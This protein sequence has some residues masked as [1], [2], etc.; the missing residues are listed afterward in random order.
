MDLNV[1]KRLAEKRV[2]GL[3]KLAADIGMSE[4]N[5]HRCINNNKMQGGDLEQIANI[6]GVSVDIFFDET[7]E[8]Y[9]D[10]VMNLK[11][12]K[13]YIEQQGLSLVSLATKINISRIALD[14]IL[15]GS[16]VK[17]STVDALA[18]ALNVNV[19][20][21]FND[22]E[23]TPVTHNVEIPSVDDNDLHEE[24]IALRAENKLLRELQGLPARR[25]VNVG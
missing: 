1:I 3:K 4:A 22:K 17:I 5:L 9:F 18:K 24:L 11:K 7:T 2:G 15:N 10:E 14:N 21:L 19:V 12:I 13:L 16:D 25:I 23:I 6:F 8:S 20:D